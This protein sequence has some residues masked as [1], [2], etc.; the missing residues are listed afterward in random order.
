MISILIIGMIVFLFVLLSYALCRAS[1]EGDS[2]FGY[3]TMSK[4]YEMTHE[5]DHKTLE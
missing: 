1:D 5:D 4:D 3:K 2:I